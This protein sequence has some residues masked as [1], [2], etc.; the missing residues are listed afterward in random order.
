MVPNRLF[1][2]QPEL[3][4]LYTA[5]DSTES[6]WMDHHVKSRVFIFIINSVSTWKRR[7]EVVGE[8]QGAKCFKFSYHGRQDLIEMSQVRT[9]C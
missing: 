4:E 7:D 8:S 2:F 5:P 6:L 9:G 3:A 1:T